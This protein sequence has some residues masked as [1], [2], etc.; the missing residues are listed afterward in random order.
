M[1]EVQPDGTGESPNVSVMIATPMYGG[2]CSGHYMTGVVGAIAALNASGVSVYFA[3]LMN[4]SLIT[5]ARNELARQFLEHGFDYLMFIDADISFD[6]GAILELLAAN[7]DI[8]CGVYPRKEIFWEGVR[9]AAHRG[10]ADL[11]EF[12]GAFA[13]N[14]PLDSASAE[15]D[16]FGL[17]EVQHGAT[18]FM[19]IKRRVFEQ[20]ASHVAEYRISSARAIDGSYHNPLTREYF[21]TSIDGTTG[22]LLSEDYHFCELWRKIG[23]KI[24]VKPS[25]RLEHVGTYVYGGDLVKSCQAR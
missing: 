16:E 1:S 13:M 3:N 24:H 9:Q 23:G 20:L 6:G 17:L 5:R 22:V 25:I 2:M 18:G 19:L 12:S 11:K 14:L 7:R 8:V 4:E 10:E 21:A 15:L